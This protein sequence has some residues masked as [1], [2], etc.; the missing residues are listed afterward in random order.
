MLTKNRTISC[1]LFAAY[2]V[3]HYVNLHIIYQD[4]KCN[5]DTEVY[6][7]E[8]RGGFGCN[9]GFGFGSWWIWIVI[10]IIIILC[11]CGGFGGIGGFGGCKK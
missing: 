11:C 1:I 10:I 3:T 5:L 8:D 6:M 7:E 2:I 4:R 9:T